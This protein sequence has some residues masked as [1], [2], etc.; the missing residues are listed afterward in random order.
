MAIFTNY[1][2]LQKETGE[3]EVKISTILCVIAGAITA[4]ALSLA[5]DAHASTECTAGQPYPNSVYDICVGYGRTCSKWMCASPPG[6]QG[7][8][9]IN[10]DYTPCTTRGGCE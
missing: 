5:Q 8:F 6:T 4:I 2:D 7:K 10:G 1:G 9:D 3:K